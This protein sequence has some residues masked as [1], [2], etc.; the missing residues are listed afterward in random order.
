MILPKRLRKL[1]SMLLQLDLFLLSCNVGKNN[2]SRMSVLVLRFSLHFVYQTGRQTVHP[3][4]VKSPTTGASAIPSRLSRSRIE[5][6]AW[7]IDVTKCSGWA[8]SKRGCAFSESPVNPNKQTNTVSFG[9]RSR[10]FQTL[11]SRCECIGR[12]DIKLSERIV[13]RG[14]KRQD[15]SGRS[16]PA[17]ESVPAWRQRVHPPRR[18]PVSKVFVSCSPAHQGHRFSGRVDSAT[19]SILLGQAQRRNE[20]Q[21]VK[22]NQCSEFQDHIDNGPRLLLIHGQQPLISLSLS[23]PQQEVKK[24]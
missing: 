14:T 1:D 12:P 8:R 19:M 18:G 16:H 6:T 24:R 22:F 15:D 23:I 21:I 10:S 9:K 11:R 13:K 17:P 2:L 4:C 5:S 3:P 7:P 20:D